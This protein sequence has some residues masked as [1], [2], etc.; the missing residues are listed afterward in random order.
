MA[1]PKKTQLKGN[2]HSGVL[3]IGDIGYMAGDLSQVIEITPDPLN[4]FKDPD[5]F[6]AKYPTDSNLELPGTVQGLT[7][8]GTIIHTNMFNGSYMVKKKVDKVTGKIKSITVTFK[9]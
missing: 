3:F 1:K 8:P 5:T 6:L 2:I 7:G 4:P 9:D